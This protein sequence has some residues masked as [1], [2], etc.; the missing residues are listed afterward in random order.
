MTGVPVSLS[1]ERLSAGIG[2]RRL[3]HG[4][5]FDAPAGCVVALVGPNGAGKSTLLR[6]LA[7][8]L[9]PDEGLVRLAG[10]DLH[11][12]PRRERARRVA[13]VEQRP[14]TDLDLTVDQV[15]ELGR[16]PHQS[17]FGGGSGADR[18]AVQGAVATAGAEHLLGRRF[19]TL[20]GG[21]RQ[22]VHLAAAL[23][24]EPALLL[25]DEPTNHLD[26]RAQ[27]ETLTLMTQLSGQGIMVV[28]ALHD[29]AHAAQ[30][31]DHVVLLA[32]GRVAANGPPGQVLTARTI[33]EVYQ[34]HVDIVAHPGTGHPVP[35]FSTARGAGAGSEQVS[36]TLKR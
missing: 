27:L 31:A 25:L 14:S 12:M 1:V 33:G 10:A 11:G 34:V 17:R 16:I 26:V 13:L 2:G 24:Q 36:V 35:L 22:R 6:V 15:V 5:G 19:T 30:Y 8:V 32:N 9:R 20:S 3:L 4:V 29:L 21:E 7:G 18:A 28:A 23:A